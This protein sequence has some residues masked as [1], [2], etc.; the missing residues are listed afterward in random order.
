MILVNKI[1]QKHSTQLQIHQA[2]ADSK[3][4]QN[5]FACYDFL[6]Y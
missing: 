1:K 2:I 5:G 4:H 6:P 3:F